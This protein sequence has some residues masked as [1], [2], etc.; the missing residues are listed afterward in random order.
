MERY[1]LAIIG[2]GPAGISAALNA[3]IR[4]KSFLLFGRKALSEKMLKS[5]KISNYPGIPEI[6][7]E[8]LVQQFQS[9]MEKMQIAVT[10]E[11]ITS[12]YNME[13]YFSLLA[14]NN[15]IY[16][17]KTVIL[18]TGMDNAAPIS[19][20]AELLGRGVSYCATCDGNLYRGKTIAVV[21]N[22]VPLEQEVNFLAGLAAKVY[23][24]PLMKGSRVAGE[25][26]EF[27]KSGVREIRGEKRV[28]SIV[29]AD[30]TELPVDG[31]F[32]IKN[33][34]PPAV[35]M[36]GLQMQD[37]HVNVDRQM[38]T[39]LKGVFAAGDCTGRPYQIA[40]AVGE[41]NVAAHAVVTYLDHQ[42]V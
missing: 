24:L 36:N 22:S 26:V 28:K 40:K 15:K 3:Q 23:Y 42:G 12:I 31:I 27:L 29:L 32:F 39:N 9:Q 19:G 38:C 4:G 5:E 13:D 37:G 10:E 8:Q 6:S 34:V 17:A 18:A 14:D 41:G 7:G 35:L 20:E 1:D 2:S 25:N 21:C 33:A 16:E 11:T 30:G